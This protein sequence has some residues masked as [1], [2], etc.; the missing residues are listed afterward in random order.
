[1]IVGCVRASYE[2][3]P[4]SNRKLVANVLE[5]DWYQVCALSGLSA[6]VSKNLKIYLHYND[7]LELRA[8]TSLEQ[9]LHTLG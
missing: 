9:N 7:W 4:K 1:M 6:F 2:P 3:T 5:K 8:G